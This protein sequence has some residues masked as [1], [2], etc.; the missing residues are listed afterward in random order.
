MSSRTRTHPKK[1]AQEEKHKKGNNEP[2]KQKMDETKGY[3]LDLA[4]R[5]DKSKGHQY[6]KGRT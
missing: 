4:W 6:T 3:V 1:K 5:Y 2:F